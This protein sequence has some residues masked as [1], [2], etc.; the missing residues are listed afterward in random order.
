MNLQVIKLG[1]LLLIICT[2]FT[3]FSN[4]YSQIGLISDFVVKPPQP[5]P[6]DFLD[7]SE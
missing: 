6:K 2:M 3:Q 1:L 7:E 5:A 4:K